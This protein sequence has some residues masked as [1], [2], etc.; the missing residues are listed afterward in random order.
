MILLWIYISELSQAVKKLFILLTM[1]QLY[2]IVS[3]IKIKNW[4]INSKAISWFLK[5][6]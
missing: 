1:F 4:L 3:I 2:D 5:F 6:V